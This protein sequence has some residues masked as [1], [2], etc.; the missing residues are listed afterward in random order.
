MSDTFTPRLNLV[1]PDFNISPWHDKVNNNFSLIDAVVYSI[2]GLA[3]IKG[4][5]VN[6]TA[7][8]VGEKYFDPET[9]VFYE[10]V[11]SYVTSPAPTTFSQER[12]LFPANW[13]VLEVATIAGAVGIVLDAQAAVLAAQAAV[14]ADEAAVEADRVSVA[15][16]KAIVAADKAQVGVWKADLDAGFVALNAAIAAKQAAATYLA[17]IVAATKAANKL[18]YSTGADSVATTDLSAF[19]RTVLDDANADAARTTLV[20]QKANDRLNEIAALTPTKGRLFIG[21]GSTIVPL[22]AGTNGKYLVTDSLEASGVKWDDNGDLFYRTNANIVGANSNAVQNLIGVGVTVEA[23]TIYEYELIYRL[24]KT[25][26]TT[27]HDMSFGF[28]GTATINNF[29]RML[30]SRFVGGTTIDNISIASVFGIVAQIA[31]NNT[32]ACSFT[33]REKGTFSVNAGGTIIPQYQLSA[34][35]GGAYTTIAGAL[36]KLRPLGVAGGDVS[37]G[38]W[39]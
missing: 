6:S 36:F 31:N 28:G 7:V 35:P 2:L 17:N 39:A 9:S 29:L 18:L 27:L 19:M 12:V 5:F 1:K 13:A 11:T 30:L 26:G 8:T 37:Q 10:V 14:A 33:M 15:A 23:N 25:A 20:A 21:D 3:N 38:T 32:A 4:P 24:T 22:D 34:A 16:D